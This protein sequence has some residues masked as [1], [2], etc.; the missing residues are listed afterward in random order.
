[1]SQLHQPQH[2]SPLTIEQHC[3]TCMEERR[4]KFKTYQV[5]YKRKYNAIQEK[6]ENMRN[7]KQTI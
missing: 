6:N 3:K 1:M 4:K 7:T 5:E 2:D